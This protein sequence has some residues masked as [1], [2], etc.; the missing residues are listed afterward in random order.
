MAKK[1]PV[2]EITDPGYRGGS[3]TDG[4]IKMKPPIKKT[5]PG[6]DIVDSLLE[7]IDTTVTT[8]ISEA[9]L[10][11]TVLCTILESD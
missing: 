10:D 1:G 7:A 9:H 8:R 11:K 5:N 3:V 6:K 2:A 4:P